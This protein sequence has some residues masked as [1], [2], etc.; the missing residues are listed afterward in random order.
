MSIKNINVSKK[1]GHQQWTGMM[2][3]LFYGLVA[4]QLLLDNL[5]L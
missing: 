1:V 4:G 3:E 5:T 2:E